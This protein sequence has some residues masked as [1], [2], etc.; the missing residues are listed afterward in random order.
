MAGF[1]TNSSTGRMLTGIDHLRQSVVNILGTP[2]G[3]R[4]ERREY[5]SA[6]TDLIDQPTN[7]A[8]ALRLKS[9]II[10]ALLR[11]EP[12]ISVQRIAIDE[13]R[14]GSLRITLEGKYKPLGN[15]IRLA[16]IEVPA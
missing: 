15:T 13:I 14:D 1:G 6:V 16:D 9:A 8:T 12:R 10:T 3:T 7:D 11:W 5:G 4:V 2:I